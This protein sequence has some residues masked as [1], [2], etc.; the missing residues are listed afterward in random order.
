MT[1]KA[2]RR[3]G[4]DI[5]DWFN[6]GFDE[7]SWEAYCYRRRDLGDLA[8]VLKTNVL[9]CTAVRSFTLLYLPVLQNF[10]GMPEDQLSALPPEVRQMV[11]TGAT[12]MMSTG[13]PNPMMG[14]GV[15]MNPMMDMSGMGPMNMGAMGMGMNGDMQM[16]M[17][18]GGPMMQDGS[19]PVSV[20]GGPVG[21]NGTPE[22]AVQ[23]GMPDGY[24]PG[25]PGAAM[26]G[27]N[28]GGDYGM[29]VRAGLIEGAL[30]TLIWLTSAVHRIQ[31][32]CQWGHRC[33]KAWRAT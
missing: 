28:M 13:G 4:S 5:S 31:I 11:M 29:Q 10:A 33:T 15:G 27:M 20:P 23:M 17:Q 30:L 22:Q 19:I 7:I 14:P 18:P 9:V 26:M 3:P 25:G 6:Y 21:S 32:R 1:E 12:A 16:Q 24:G 8:S 2:W